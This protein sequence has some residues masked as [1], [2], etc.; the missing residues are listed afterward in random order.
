MSWCQKWWYSHR[1]WFFNYLLENVSYEMQ[2]LCNMSIWLV[3]S[4]I[5][6]HTQRNIARFPSFSQLEEYLLA[7]WIFHTEQMEKCLCDQLTSGALLVTF[8]MDLI[9]GLVVQPQSSE[10]LTCKWMQNEFIKFSNVYTK[11][12]ESRVQQTNIKVEWYNKPSKKIPFP[13]ISR[14][15]T[16]LPFSNS[17]LK[18]TTPKMK[19]KYTP[20]SN[21]T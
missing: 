21:Q 16:W 17:F 13:T 2:I 4:V 8:R 7:N 19:W 6:N 1:H 9:W 3:N 14:H 20:K 15:D 10:F 18:H 12:D 11:E 5:A